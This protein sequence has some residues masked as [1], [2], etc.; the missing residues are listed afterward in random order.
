MP[1]QT[2]QARSWSAGALLLLC[3]KIL[4]KTQQGRGWL[5]KTNLLALIF[6]RAAFAICSQPLQR[7]ERG[8][9]R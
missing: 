3:P 5:E 1:P 6:I 9:S 4:I 2:L 7:Q 8:R